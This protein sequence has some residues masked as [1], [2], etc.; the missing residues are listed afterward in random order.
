MVDEHLRHTITAHSPN[1]VSVSN[2]VQ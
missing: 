2:A 1:S